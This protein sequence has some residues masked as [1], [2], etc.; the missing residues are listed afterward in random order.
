MFCAERTQMYPLP[1]S[2]YFNIAQLAFESNIVIGLRMMRLAAG[3]QDAADEAQLMVTEKINTATQLA[4]ENSLAL[5]SG[6]SLES[7]SNSSIARY[8][9]AVKANHRRLT[10]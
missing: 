10:R 6:K 4:M 8:R 7:V 5:A 9:K 2:M 1:M 3:G